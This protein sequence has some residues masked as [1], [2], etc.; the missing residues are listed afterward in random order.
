M[1]RIAYLL[2]AFPTWSET[3][4]LNELRALRCRG[5]EPWVFTLAEGEEGV[6]HP[7]LDELLSRTFLLDTGYGRP[8]MLGNAARGV[9]AGPLDWGR[10]ERCARIL[11]APY[12]WLHRLT[13]RHA[14]E[15]RRLGISRV[16]V[17]FGGPALRWGALLALEAAVPLSVTLHRYDIFAK[18]LP[19][20]KKLEEVVDSWVTVSRFNKRYM[21]EVL[22]LDGDRISVIPCGVDTSFFS[23]GRPQEKKPGKILTVARLAEEKGLFH[24]LEAASVLRERGLETQ[25][26]VV[27]DGPERERLEKDIRRRGLSGRVRLLGPGRS[28]EVRSHLRQAEVFALPSLSEGAP[29]SYMEAMAV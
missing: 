2:D 5:F 16:H 1:T 21:E 22:G 15:L 23:P 8:A 25:W 27:G 28:T 20:L 7:G 13:S 24:L 12:P 26:V 6:D 19:E 11:G 14:R 18:P 10:T 29:V 17:H 3:F 9:L 4:V